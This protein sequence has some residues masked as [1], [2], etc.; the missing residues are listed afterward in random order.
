M[1]TSLLNL[2]SCSSLELDLKTRRKN[3]RRSPLGICMFDH[4]LLAFLLMYF[5]CIKKLG[6][7]PQ[8]SFFPYWFSTSGS[9]IC[10]VSEVRVFISIPFKEQ[11]F[12]FEVCTYFFP[13]F[14][15]FIVLRRAP[16]NLA[17]FSRQIKRHCAEPFTEYWTCIDYS[18]L[19]LFRRC[20]KQQAKFDDC[21]LDKLGWVRPDLGELSK[22]K[23]SVSCWQA[24]S[25][26]EGLVKARGGLK[27]VRECGYDSRN[28]N[29]LNRLIRERL[30][31]I[32]KG[33]YLAEVLLS[34]A[35][36]ACAD[37]FVVN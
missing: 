23:N 28:P 7:S 31:T 35:L 36:A 2:L 20:R 16:P 22:V 29:L 21:V 12:V 18:G 26:T 33:V 17:L 37:L 25:L 6:L 8:K 3:M 14:L 13:T 15:F 24:H 9:P 10:L 11:G 32:L 1:P 5:C 19:Q 34:I 27:R 4:G 30:Y